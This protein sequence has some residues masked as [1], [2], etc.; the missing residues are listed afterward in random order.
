MK[1]QTSRHASKM[2]PHR[3]APPPSASTIDLGGG[4]PGDPALLSERQPIL[5]LLEAVLPTSS[6]C[7]PLL[8]S[9]TCAALAC[10]SLTA[11]LAIVAVGAPRSSL[12]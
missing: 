7:L 3:G 1:K 4:C 11:E 10:N 12:E 2:F 5:G 8:K 9:M 6:S